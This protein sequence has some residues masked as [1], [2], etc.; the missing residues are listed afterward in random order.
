MKTLPTHVVATVEEHH[1]VASITAFRAFKGLLFR[2]DFHELGIS[3]IGVI[4]GILWVPELSIDS[5]E[6]PYA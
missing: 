2:V 3:G 5:N 6:L 1:Q 4:G